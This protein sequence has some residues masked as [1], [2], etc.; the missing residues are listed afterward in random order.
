MFPE[1]EFRE[2]QRLN[3]N[4]SSLVCFSG[5]IKGRNWLSKKTI[6]KNFDKLVE[7]TDYSKKDRIQLLT[8]LYDL[9]E[10]DSLQKG[11]LALT[12]V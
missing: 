8:G 12:K 5:I 6:R 4:W 7:R 9:A 1:E 2:I 10:G 3:P 11:D